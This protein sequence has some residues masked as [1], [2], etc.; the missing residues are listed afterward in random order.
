VYTFHGF[1]FIS[2]PL[3]NYLSNEKEFERSDFCFDF[4]KP[5]SIPSELRKSQFAGSSPF[6]GSPSFHSI[7]FGNLCR[8]LERFIDFREPNHLLRFLARSPPPPGA[9]PN[10]FSLADVSQ[11]YLFRISPCLFVE[12]GPLNGPPFERSSFT[13]L[14]LSAVV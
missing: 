3:L 13:S 5:E 1:F 7:V 2:N 11:V 9:L 4:S 12:A 10:L 14:F 8:W 6:F